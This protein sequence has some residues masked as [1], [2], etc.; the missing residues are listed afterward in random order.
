MGDATNTNSN[1]QLDAE[2]NDPDKKITFRV[3]Y[4]YPSFV[5]NCY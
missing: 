2:G 4:F 3:P 5:Q 1:Y